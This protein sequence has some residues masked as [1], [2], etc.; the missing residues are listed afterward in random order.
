[1]V[2]FKLLLP[3]A[4]VF[5]EEAPVVSLHSTIFVGCSFAFALVGLALA[6]EPAGTD[7]PAVPPRAIAVVLTHNLDLVE[8]WVQEKDLA[9]AAKSAQDVTLLAK[10]LSANA[11]SN[12][13]LGSLVKETDALLRAA[14]ARKLEDTQKAL[15]AAR[16]TIAW[17][18]KAHVGIQSPRPGEAQKTKEKIGTVGPLMALMDGTYADTKGMDKAYDF[19]AFAFT[20]AEEANIVGLLR[21]DAKWKKMSADVR[22]AALAAAKESRQDLVGARKTLRTVYPACEA[23]H[24][25]YRR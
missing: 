12:S 7:Q 20:L 23:C 14:R 16:E 22:D 13:Q 1:M 2:S 24:K 25:A 4:L 19:E 21:P 11:A 15:A 6:D 18:Q 10:L 8:K 17:L 9:S 5:D 3:L